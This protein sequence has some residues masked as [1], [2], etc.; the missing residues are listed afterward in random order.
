MRDFLTRHRATLVVAAVFLLAWAL[1]VALEPSPPE[2][3]VDPLDR[4]V[5]PAPVGVP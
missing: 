5:G 3:P 2:P 4:L 1:A